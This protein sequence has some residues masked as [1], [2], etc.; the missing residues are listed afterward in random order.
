[1][2]IDIEAIK[3]KLINLNVKVSVGEP[4]NFGDGKE[5]NPFEAVIKQ[6]SVRLHFIEDKIKLKESVL[7]R[8]THPFAYNNLKCEYFLASP[9]HVGIGLQAFISGE[10][11]SFNFLRIS[12]E[13][14]FCDYPFDVSNGKLNDKHFGLIGSLKK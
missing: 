5:S 13:Q 10:N 8:A 12:S 6:V 1:M 14:A 9:R 7:L 4:W 3:N 11:V 2:D